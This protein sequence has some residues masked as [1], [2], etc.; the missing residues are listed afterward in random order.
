MTDGNNNNGKKLFINESKNDTNENPAQDYF[1]E[2]NPFI[3]QIDDFP[4]LSK[5]CNILPN[6]NSNVFR[7]SD[8]LKIS[9]EVVG[10]H[11][12]SM[13]DQLSQMAKT[14]EEMINETRKRTSNIY[15]SKVLNDLYVNFI[16]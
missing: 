11:K 15:K 13:F 2:D 16:F 9:E 6:A 4:I 12:N 3:N 14:H 1:I 8:N 10:I 5:E 7:L